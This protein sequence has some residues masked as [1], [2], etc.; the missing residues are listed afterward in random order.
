MTERPFITIG[1]TA[2]NEERAIGTCL[3]SLIAS[4]AFA[5]ETV[6]SRFQIIVVLDD[7]T[8]N[9]AG[10]VRKYGLPTIVSSGGLVEAQRQLADRR[11]FVLFCD[12][13]LLVDRVTIGALAGAMMNAPSLQ[14]A[15]ASKS[16]LP[17]SRRTL[18]AEALYSYN[19]TNGFQ[20]KRRYFCG[21]CFAIR[22]WQVPTLAE[23]QPRLRVLPQDHFYNFHAGMRID[24]IYLSRDIL[25][26]YGGAAIREIPEAHVRFKPP[27]TFHGMY[28]TYLRM[29]MEIERLDLLFPDSR[30]AHQRRSTDAAQTRQATR[31]ELFLLRV[32][33]FYLL[34]CRARYRLERFYY[35]RVS[36]E[37]CPAWP[38]VSESKILPC[39]DISPQE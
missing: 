35:Q 32:F 3:E 15:Y 19:R 23:L 33:N 1:V 29:R 5:E 24:D 22:D 36:K 31:R 8:D 10:V 6:A 26:R 21:K 25:K 14:V 38:I 9:T 20:E 39:H 18:I 28:H 17:P 27:Q 16:P 4:V 11:P 34:L 13:D 7:C 12:A 30:P 2:K 37:I